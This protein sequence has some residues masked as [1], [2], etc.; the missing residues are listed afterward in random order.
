MLGCCEHESNPPGCMKG[1]GFLKV[2][3]LLGSQ[4]RFLHIELFIYCR[5]THS[6]LVTSFRRLVLC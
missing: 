6:D 1:R 5:F 4:E 2:E 3:W